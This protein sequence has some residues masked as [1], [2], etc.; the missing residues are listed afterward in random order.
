MFVLILLKLFQEALK[1]N[2]RAL[3]DS[4]PMYYSFAAVYTSVFKLAR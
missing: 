4:V 2:I 3:S 1:V